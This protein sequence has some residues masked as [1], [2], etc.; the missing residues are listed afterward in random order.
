MRKEIASFYTIAKINYFY[1]KKEFHSKIPVEI[2]TKLKMW[3]K[4]FLGESYHIYDL[5][6]KDLST[7][8]SDKQRIKSNYI[9]GK[10]AFVLNNKIVFEQMYKDLLNI[11]ETLALVNKVKIFSRNEKVKDVATLVQYIEAKGN[12]VIKPISGGGGFGVRILKF[13]DGKLYS[14]NELTTNE[15]LAN[16]ISK[17]DEYFISEFI[18]QGEFSSSLNPATLNSMRI[19]TAID[20]DT[21]EAFIP[22]AVQRIGTNK[23]APADNWTQGGISAEIDIKTGVM[24]KGASYPSDGN[25]VWHKNHPDTGT[26]IE[27]MRIP[28][29]DEIK[30]IIINTANTHPYIKYIGWDVVST[31]DGIMVIE[32]NNCTD[33]N[34]LQIHRPLLK[35]KRLKRFYKYY[36]VI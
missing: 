28:Y 20:P 12:V 31:D 4:G 5:N 17:M 34:L 21:N 35:D 26:Q 16:D 11:P 10:Y 7:Y 25:L 36:N 22:I 8:L 23:S 30:E 29:W 1:W 15:K 27:G 3:R 19:V 24:K 9:N 33:V 6:S 32:A 14:N 18:H 13:K 2:S